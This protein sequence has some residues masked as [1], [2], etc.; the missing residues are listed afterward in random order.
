MLLRSS[1]IQGSGVM[2]FVMFENYHFY[3]MYLFPQ[4]VKRTFRPGV[5]SSQCISY[6]TSDWTGYKDVGMLGTLTS[7][8]C[9]MR[10]SSVPWA[11]L[12]ANLSNLA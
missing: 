9:K 7:K 6:H 5:G 4:K 12:L 1:M 10:L 8:R 2:R 3:I 11:S